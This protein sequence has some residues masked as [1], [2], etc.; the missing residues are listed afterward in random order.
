MKAAPAAHPRPKLFSE[1]KPH[2]R[3][4]KMGDFFVN[5]PPVPSQR[6]SLGVHKQGK[7]MLSHHSTED[8]ADCLV[9]TK[10]EQAAWRRE[11]KNG[12]EQAAVMGRE[13][14]GEKNSTIASTYFGPHCSWR[15]AHI[16]HCSLSCLLCSLPYLTWFGISIATHL[17]KLAITSTWLTSSQNL[18]SGFL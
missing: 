3:A 18:L 7:K 16:C 12:S 4:S 8:V 13:C 14:N 11:R 17:I 5:P 9:S 1:Q 15:H 6:S 10:K 2:C